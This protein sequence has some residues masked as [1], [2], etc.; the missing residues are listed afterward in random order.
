ML[1]SV[2]TLKDRYTQTA[3]KVGKSAQNMGMS[4]AKSSKDADK[5]TSSLDKMTKSN[6]KMSIKPNISGLIKAS[7]ESTKL[8]KE[9]NKLTGKSH[10]IKV[11]LSGVNLG[12]ASAAA[13]SGGGFKAALMSGIATATI[14]GILAAAAGT[15]LAVK[16]MLSNG[17]ELEQQKIA[18]NH[19]LVGD[20]AKSEAYM[21]ELRTNANK[22]PFSTAEV[23]AAG[24]RAIQITEGDTKKG[25]EMVKLAEDMAALNPGKTISDAMEALADAKMGEMERLKE[26]GFK[27]SKELFDAAGGDLMKMKSISGKSL[28]E[29][30]AGG[31]DK[32]SGAWKGKVS[33]IM[34][35]LQSGIA[36]S[37]IKLIEALGPSLEKL[38]PVSERL[39]KKLPEITEAVINVAGPALK[40]LGGIVKEYVIP[41]F[42]WLGSAI[43]T[44]VDVVQGVVGAV[45]GFLSKEKKAPPRDKFA[46]GTSS[47]QGGWATVNERGDEMFKLPNRTKIYPSSKTDAI[48]SR[49]IRNQGYRGQQATFNMTFNI[50]T[51]GEVDE[52]KLGKMV[53]YEIEKVLVNIK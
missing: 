32:L 47:F 13:G 7:L 34:G 43:K 8:A 15:G 48:L 50:N 52:S 36:E 27:G 39:A 17:S 26:F 38:I 4:L 37:G 14:A 10:K 16:S 9:L 11:A 42:K 5:L 6:R 29:M 49:E 18:M 53:A 51:G 28:L 44:V 20:Q 35:N 19:F 33:T 22:T 40:T 31:A 45:S 23:V 2:I 41:T 21:K 12:G 24:A 46:T 25:M 3:K 1:S 30:Y